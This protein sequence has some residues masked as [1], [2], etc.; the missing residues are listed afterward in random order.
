MTIPASPFLAGIAVL[1]LATGTAHA[2]NKRVELMLF[3]CGGWAEVTLW[4]EIYPNMGRSLVLELPNTG[5]DAR[6]QDPNETFVFKRGDKMELSYNGTKCEVLWPA[7]Q[8]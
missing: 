6:Y 8:G 2:E 5:P 7:E 3:K 4:E 1:F